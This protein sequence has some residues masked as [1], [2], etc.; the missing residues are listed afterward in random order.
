MLGFDISATDIRINTESNKIDEI[1][2]RI[3]FSIDGSKERKSE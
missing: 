1:N 3:D 2:T